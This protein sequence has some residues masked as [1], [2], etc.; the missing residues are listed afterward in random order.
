MPQRPRTLG[1]LMQSPQAAEPIVSDNVLA[2]GLRQRPFTVAGAFGVPSFL[3]RLLSGKN[4]LALAKDIAL[5]FSGGGMIKVGGS[6]L[7]VS[8]ARAIVTGISRFDRNPVKLVKSLVRE[9]VIHPSMREQAKE[10]AI[11]VRETNF[12]R[13]PNRY[14]R[15]PLIAR[16]GVRKASLSLRKERRANLQKVQSLPDFE[17]ISKFY[18]SVALKKA[19]IDPE[20]ALS[21][22]VRGKLRVISS[23]LEKRGWRVQH[24]SSQNGRITSRYLKSPDGVSQIRISDHE[25]PVR[26]SNDAIYGRFKGLGDFVVRAE[27]SIDDVINEIIGP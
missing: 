26:S 6:G 14:F 16:A 10:F 1:E 13:R 7:P 19:E 21:D 22:V 27:D 15:D 9:G 5:G 3:D 17:R 11:Q 23:A 25:L 4:T 12:S 2:E 8:A 20:R 18:K 24:K